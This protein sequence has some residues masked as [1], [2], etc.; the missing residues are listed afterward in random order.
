MSMTPARKAQLEEL[1][2]QARITL[3]DMLYQKQTGHP[4]GSLSVCEILAA[5]YLE[6]AN[7]SPQ[8]LDD[9]HRDR[10]VL[11]KGHAAPMLY[12]VLAAAGY[13]PP[14]ELGSL[15]DLNTR[16][17]GHPSSHSLP[18]VEATTGPLGLGLSA[19]LG[20][21]VSLGMDQSPATV[22][23]VM[24]DG[25]LNEGACWEAAMSAAKYKPHNLIAIVDCNGVQL[26]GS[27]RDIMPLGDLAAK[28][29]A[30]GWHVCCCDGH[31]VE[32]LCDNLDLAKTLPGPCVILAKTVKGKGIS[33][34]EGKSQWHGKPIDDASYAMARAQLQ[35]GDRQ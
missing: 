11:T 16:L 29:R 24:G 10:I 1:C 35:G 8:R 9:P 28:F 13:L 27:T 22:Y 3:L 21:A 5:L 4:G 7:I 2:R 26:D 14:Q 33:F 30:F 6:K 12:V 20:M 15:R 25:E 18:A 31:N 19:A 32:E 34:M 17:Q 23:A